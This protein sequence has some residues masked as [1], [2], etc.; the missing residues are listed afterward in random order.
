MAYSNTQQQTAYSKAGVFLTLSFVMFVLTLSSFASI[1]F[2][3]YY[4]DGTKPASAPAFVWDVDSTFAVHSGEG[5]R[6]SYLPQLGEEEVQETVLAANPERIVI[7]SIGVDL[8]V[9]N[10]ESTDIDVLDAEL[11]KGT[12]RYPD[13]ARLGEQGNVFI[14][15]H[16]SGIPVVRNQMYK[17][18]N[19]LSELKEGDTINVQG[20]DREYIYR[21]QTVRLT[22][23]DE[24]MID[25]SREGGSRL[26]LSTCNS[27]GEKSERWVVEAEL[28]GSYSSLN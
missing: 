11:Q 6:L 9:L 18:F 21:V 4:V 25:L 8:P 1:G 22:E 20:G 12:V 23:A 17:A 7:R 14:F 10:P 24:A 15:G 28:V 3:P 5:V 26:T 19:R 13:S 27:F 16:S 2:V